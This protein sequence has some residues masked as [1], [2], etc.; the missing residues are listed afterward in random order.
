VASHQASHGVS[1][2]TARSD[3]QKLAA[4]ELL[5]SRRSGRKEVFAVPADLARRLPAF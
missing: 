3:L 4:Q 1:N 2:Q 5:V